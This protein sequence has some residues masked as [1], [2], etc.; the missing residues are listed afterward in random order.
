[1]LEALKAVA[2]RLKAGE[3]SKDQAVKEARAIS[4]RYAT[5]INIIRPMGFHHLIQRL[6]KAAKLPFAIHP[7]C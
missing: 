7:H 6:G 4:A 1:M 3:I 5:L 2:E